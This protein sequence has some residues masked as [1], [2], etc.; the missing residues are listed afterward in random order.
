MFSSGCE[1]LC[2]EVC[3]HSFHGGVCG[4]QLTQPLLL[5]WN[6]HLRGHNDGYGYSSAISRLLKDDEEIGHWERDVK[7]GWVLAFDLCSHV[8]ITFS[9]KPSNSSW[10][11]SRRYFICWSASRANAGSM[12]LSALVT[13][14]ACKTQQIRWKYWLELN[15]VWL[16]LRCWRFWSVMELHR[17]WYLVIVHSW[18]MV[19]TDF[20]ED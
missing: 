5:S 19:W 13:P 9:L 8:L 1:A 6:F 4:A 11:R 14:A 10:M 16:E 12:T 7:T 3:H 2:I 15:N 20:L 18:R 17:V